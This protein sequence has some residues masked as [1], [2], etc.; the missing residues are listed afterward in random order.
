MATTAP[1]TMLMLGVNVV[2]YVVGMVAPEAGDQ[3]FRWMAQ[4]NWLVEEGEWWRMLTAAFLHAGFTHILFNGWALY[5]F[6]PRLE[7]QVGSAAFLGLYLASAVAGGAAA[8]LL[9]DIGDVVVGAS[10]AIFGL[11]GAWLFSAWRVRHTRMGRALFQQLVVLLAINAMLPLI[12]PRISW[13]GHLGGL[14]AGVVIASIW[15]RTPA[16]TR[17][18]EMIRA[19]SA[20]VVGVIAMILATIV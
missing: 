7:Q 15:S 6:G 10:G 4:A 14:V 17:S 11:F 16:R 12:A 18:D 8:Y 5:V 2:I 20:A 9:G 1:I 3:L 13:Q 19:G